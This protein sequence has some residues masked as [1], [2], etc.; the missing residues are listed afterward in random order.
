[1]SSENTKLHGI[2]EWEE[3]NREYPEEDKIWGD[4]IDILQTDNVDLIILN[5]A[6]AN[7]A[8]SALRGLP[9]VIKDYKLYLEFMLLVTREAEDYYNFV[10]NSE[11]YLQ[12]FIAAVKSSI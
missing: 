8:A 3:Q 9:L 2:I 12:K 7:I 10:Q 5:R 1:M 6:P 4:L 11:P